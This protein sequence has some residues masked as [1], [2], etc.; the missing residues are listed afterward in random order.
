MNRREAREN[1]FTLIFEYTYKMDSD[2][3]AVYAEALEHRCMQDD[4]YV[5]E[6]F[7]A[8]SEN[9]DGIDKKI[10]SHSSGWS[11]SR[12]SRV[13]IS[14]MRI[15][16]YEMTMRSDIPYNISINEA[17]ELTKKYDDEKAAKFVNGILNAIA[18][19]EGLKK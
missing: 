17:L 12:L 19:S 6:A 13:V 15:S 9:L 10:E 4:A 8:I 18:G 3:A 1:L 11:V 2:P 7:T 16:V 14:I 5:R